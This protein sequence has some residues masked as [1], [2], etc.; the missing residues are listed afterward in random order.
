[1]RRARKITP[2]KQTMRAAVPVRR[3]ELLV[4]VDSEEDAILF[5][6]FTL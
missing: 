6:C 2:T 3:L 4:L 1:M 5:I